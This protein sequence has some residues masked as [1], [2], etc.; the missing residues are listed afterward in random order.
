MPLDFTNPG[1]LATSIL[2]ETWAQLGLRTAVICPGSR[3]T[4]LAFA[5]A[6]HPDIDTVPVLDE[7]AAAFLALGRARAAHTPVAVVCT[8]GTAAA[9][10]LPA[11]VEAYES[12]VPLL[13]LTA[14]RPQEL[15]DI[16]SNQAIDQRGLFGRHAVWAAELAVPSNDPALAPHFR[17]AALHA[18]ERCQ[19]PQPGA[20]HLNCPFRE[21]LVPEPDRHTQALAARLD[22]KVVVG[23]PEFDAPRFAP[24]R[25][26]DLARLVQAIARHERGLI[27]CGPNAPRRPAAFAEAAGKLAA[28]LGWP[29]LADATSPLRFHPGAV[30]TLCEAYDA[31][32]RGARAAAALQPACV[33]VLGSLPTSKT[34][35]TWL[36]ACEPET[37]VFGATGRAVN[38]QLAAH[39]HH[40][41]AVEEFAAL[42]APTQRRNTDYQRAWLEADGAA[43]RALREGLAALPPAAPF[44]EGRAAHV[45]ADKL[46]ANT[47]V[48]VGNS[49]PPRDFEFFGFGRES[50]LRVFTNRGASGI[51]GLVATAAG[52]AHRN[53]PAVAYLG[54]LSLLH[55]ATGLL[56]AQAIHGSL[57]LVVI[58]NNG[59]GIFEMLPVARFEPPFERLIAMPQRADLAAL[60]A[61]FGAQHVRIATVQQLEQL[62][63]EL[64]A[65]GV[66]VLEVTADRRKDAATRRTLLA[67]AGTAA[68]RTLA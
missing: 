64:P 12:G 8:S 42:P 38:P 26:G 7:R 44:F 23:A 31:V 57:T 60:C 55:D 30:P 35:R 61:A 21:P 4:P 18:W 41:V 66:R 49:T 17:Q 67:Q 52:V 56:A 59:G 5:F 13:L 20:V 2:V 51:D 3:N 16:G 1:T 36:A 22:P 10:F 37:V 65:S 53:Q 19:F 27:L 9:N 34:L 39:R 63:A 28:T 32:L 68:E 43:R 11:A 33:V 15:R 47:P 29:V 45:L 54:D 14:D 24:Q 62:L 40:R 58:N 48:L 25:P 50:R 6:R 46:P